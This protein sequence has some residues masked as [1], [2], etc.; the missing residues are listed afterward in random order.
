MSQSSTTETY[1]TLAPLSTETVQFL[2]GQRYSEQ[3]AVH[4]VTS[5]LQ[6]ANV[7]QSVW[8]TL[9][10]QIN[11]KRQETFEVLD[12]LIVADRNVPAKRKQLNATW[13]RTNLALYGPPQEQ[14][15]LSATTISRWQEQGVLRKDGWNL[16]EIQSV[17]ELF[18]TRMVTT[19]ERGWL[20]ETMSKG[21]WW[22]CWS[23][24]G[25]DA[26]VVPCPYPL[27][28]NLSPWTLL[29]TPWLGASWDAAWL[30]LPYQGCIRFAGVASKK[31]P[32]TLQREHLER[33]DPELALLHTRLAISTDLQ[34]LVERT[35]QKLAM[36][37]L[38]SLILS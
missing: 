37:R 36:D 8:W 13:V 22:W 19:R 33:W 21:A 2:F 7:A 25:P 1:P 28:L 11:E 6:A 29:W 34:S 18:I 30:Q 26:P 23:Q 10:R 35:L 14:S 12:P 27:P 32:A 16:L 24:D 4:P 20:P 38:R 3:V 5:P 15:P 17:A 9:E 31:G